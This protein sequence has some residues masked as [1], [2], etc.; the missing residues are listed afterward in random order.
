MKSDKK[1]IQALLDGKA[2]NDD[3]VE[4]MMDWLSRKTGK[5]VLMPYI[6]RQ[7]CEAQVGRKIAKREWIAFVRYVYDRGDA[8]YRAINKATQQA[9]DEFTEEKR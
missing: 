9:W 7:D 3:E 2:R 6:T 4:E 5:L 1:L 8:F